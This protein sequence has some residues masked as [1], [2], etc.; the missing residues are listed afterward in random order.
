MFNRLAF[1][2][3]LCPTEISDHIILEECGPVFC[4]LPYHRPLS[5]FSSF[6]I[7]SLNLTDGVESILFPA[8]FVYGLL[9]LFLH[10]E[11]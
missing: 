6:G 3:H 4:R 11:G 8:M 7:Y 5:Y 1:G 2:S 10:P 9:P